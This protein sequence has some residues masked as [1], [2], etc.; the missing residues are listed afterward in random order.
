VL[1]APSVVGGDELPRSVAEAVAAQEA[2]GRRVLLLAR[3]SQS[4][5]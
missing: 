3:G 4:L 2:A 5:D 1:G